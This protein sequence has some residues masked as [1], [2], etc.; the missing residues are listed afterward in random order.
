MLMNTRL[1]PYTV[2][3][4]RAIVLMHN[5]LFL[6]SCHLRIFTLMTHDESDQIGSMKNTSQDVKCWCLQPPKY[7]PQKIETEGFS[8]FPGS[9]LR[10]KKMYLNVNLIRKYF[11]G[12]MFVPVLYSFNSG[13]QLPLIICKNNLTE[14][15]YLMALLA[16]SLVEFVFLLDSLL[17][18]DLPASE[19]WV[20]VEGAQM[21]LLP[22]A[23]PIA[24][25]H[26]KQTYT[27]WKR[28][29]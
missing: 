11:W 12:L 4:L 28:Q 10:N 24:I 1:F 5:S 2:M 16:F 8:S 14:W 27:Q 3:A 18:S 6:S 19:L 15:K 13:I 25:T 23:N 17:I 22:S 26:R 9:F 29:Q 7:N 21:L 20:Y